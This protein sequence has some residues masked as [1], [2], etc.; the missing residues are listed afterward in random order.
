MPARAAAR[1]T[2]VFT[3]VVHQPGEAGGC[4]Y[5]WKGTVLPEHD[6]G[7]VDIRYVLQ[8]AWVKGAV[9][10]CISGIPDAHFF[11]CGT[12]DIVEGRAGCPL[13]SELT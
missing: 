5:E 2:A 8:D 1:A 13:A 12:V 10:I 3:F 11:V 9:S 7:G 4:E 6:G